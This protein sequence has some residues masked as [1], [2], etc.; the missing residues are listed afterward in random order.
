MIDKKIKSFWNER[1]A[2]L[3]TKWPTKKCNYEISDYGR[4]KS[5]N[6]ESGEERLLKG[7][8]VQRGQILLNIRLQGNHKQG[9]YVHK[10][11]AEQFVQ[12]T[13][14]SQEFIIHLDQN[15]ENNHYKNLKWV[16]QREL[17]DWQIAT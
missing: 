10:F 13:D 3:V 14:D 6:K 15:K 12:K 4:V 2:Q 9:I 5:I 17:T 11:V 16:N 1:W 8:K 7:S